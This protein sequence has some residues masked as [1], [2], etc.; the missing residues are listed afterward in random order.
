MKKILFYIISLLDYVFQ[1]NNKKVVYT[2]FPDFSDNSFAMFI[3]ISNNYQE[4]QSIWLIDKME[5][6]DLYKKMTLNYTKND[7]Y[8][9]VK[10]N[11][12]IGI[13]YYLTSKYVFFS[14]G[15]YTGVSI[16]KNHFVINLWH[17]MPLKSIAYLDVEFKGIIQKA[18][19]IISTSP[20]YQE[21]LANAFKINKSNVLVTGQPRNDL[22]L[23]DS[24]NISY[25]F[26]VKD[27]YKNIFMWMPTYR[28]SILGD[29]RVD[30]NETDSLPII[31]IKDLDELNLVLKEINSF[32]IIKLHPMDILTLKK[33]DIYTNISII[34]NNDL[35]IKGMQLYTLLAD[36][37]VLLT[38]YSSV[39]IDFLLTGKPIAFI[40]ED[41]EAYFNSR[42]FVFN[43]PVDY[44][45]GAIIT[46]KE[47]FF[48]FL[49]T[50]YIHSNYKKIALK[51][52]S[53]IEN[54]SENIFRKV[55]NK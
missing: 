29:I 19:Y 52:N 8:K 23:T 28:R 15:L 11:S 33:F 12:L 3:Y 41:M 30:G 42:G 36:I 6:V 47:S 5:K 13:Y 20:M 18:K 32:M 22:L 1:K 34:K 2:S 21:I 54:S 45:P 17:G 50:P 51:F 37:D 10:K 31:S 26:V 35:E 4:Y 49:K 39:Y 43:R 44:M 25:K 46:N 38:D 40:V 53:V 24:S 48:E 7:K 9:I 27:S 14:H 16:P 55:I